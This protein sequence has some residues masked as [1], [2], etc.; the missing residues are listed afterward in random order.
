MI[1]DDFHEEYLIWKKWN[2][3]YGSKNVTVTYP[4]SV[5][6]K[7]SS[8]FPFLSYLT[9]SIKSRK[10]LSRKPKT[11]GRSTKPSFCGILGSDMRFSA[12]VSVNKRRRSI[13][14]LLWTFSVTFYQIARGGGCNWFPWYRPSLVTNENLKYFDQQIINFTISRLLG[15]VR[16]FFCTL[17]LI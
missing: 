17:Y 14:R 3:V 15:S 2:T 7:C 1:H 9:V 4:S 10:V 16:L 13:A 8:T 5:G 12:A 11:A 6:T